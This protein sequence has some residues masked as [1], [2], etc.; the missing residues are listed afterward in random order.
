MFILKRKRNYLCARHP[1]RCF[2]KHDHIQQLQQF[3]QMGSVTP[4]F[5]DG[6][7]EAEGDKKLTKVPHSLSGVEPLLALVQNASSFYIA[8][9]SQF[10]ALCHVLSGILR[11]LENIIPV[12]GEFN[13]NG[14]RS[15]SYKHS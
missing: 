11:T 8:L 6:K 4:I 5:I 7:S 13:L 3:F 15:Q 9:G 14:E 10:W 2:Y 1:A 12:L